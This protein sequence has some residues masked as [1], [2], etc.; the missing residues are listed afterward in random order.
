MSR[1]SETSHYIWADVV[2]VSWQRNKKPF[3]T[4]YSRLP[5]ARYSLSVWMKHSIIALRTKSSPTAGHRPALHRLQTSN[6]LL[7][8][9]LS[10]CDTPSWNLALITALLFG[11]FAARRCFLRQRHM[12]NRRFG[13]VWVGVWLGFCLHFW[14]A[15]V[16]T[17]IHLNCEQSRLHKHD[18]CFIYVLMCHYAIWIPNV[19]CWLLMESPK[20]GL[21]ASKFK[22]HFHFLIICTAHQSENGLSEPF[23]SRAYSALIGQTAQS[24]FHLWRLP[25]CL[26]HS[27]T[28]N[29]VGLSISMKTN[30]SRHVDNMN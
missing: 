1:D 3:L 23:F 25:W 7:N 22:Q 27:D 19:V 26:I 5:A 15:N 12:N 13:L 24:E 9:N 10:N 14:E 20:I 4:L 16:K 28:N 2:P 30:S 18:K 21:H 11:G 17:W 6:N 29:G 8:V